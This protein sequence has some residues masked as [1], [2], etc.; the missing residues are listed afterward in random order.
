MEN[1]LKRLNPSPRQVHCELSRITPAER[2]EA[3]MHSSDPDAVADNFR[4]V[5]DPGSV[6][7]DTELFGKELPG[8][9]SCPK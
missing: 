9:I 4:A 7:S 8:W 1:S 3:I 6:M 2:L 5:L